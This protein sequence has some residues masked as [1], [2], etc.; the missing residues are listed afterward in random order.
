MLIFLLLLLL[1]SV[2]LARLCKKKKSC[3]HLNRTWQRDGTQAKE[4]VQIWGRS[5]SFTMNLKICSLKSGGSCW[6]L[7]LRE[8]CLPSCFYKIFFV[9]FAAKHSNS[10]VKAL[11]Y[12]VLPRVKCL[13]YMNIF[14][15][16]LPLVA[17]RG[18][19]YIQHKWCGTKSARSIQC[20]K[21]YSQVCL[22]LRGCF[23]SL[24]WTNKV[25]IQ[26]HSFLLWRFLFLVNLVSWIFGGY[27]LHLSNSASY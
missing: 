9:K 6:T 7:A 1:L 13:Q 2:Y 23:S 20:K 5:R 17:M 3:T 22:K 25:D 16:I 15:W 10:N 4:A 14:F 11:K 8:V 24:S 12:T 26:V 27:L 21:M 19:L 18:S